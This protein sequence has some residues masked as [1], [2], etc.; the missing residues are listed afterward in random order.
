MRTAQWTCEKW[1]PSMD[2]I[3]AIPNRNVGIPTFNVTHGQVN[4]RG[5]GVLEKGED[6]RNSC[7]QIFESVWSLCGLAD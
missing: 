7:I 5:W 3:N 6:K 4:F 2:E 1:Q